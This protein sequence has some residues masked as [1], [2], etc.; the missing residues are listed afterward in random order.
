MFAR[1]WRCARTPKYTSR[2]FRLL[3]TEQLESRSVLAALSPLASLHHLAVSAGSLS[4][5][6]VK[7]TAPVAPTVAKAASASVNSAGCVTG[8]ST[9]LAVLGSDVKG[10]STLTYTWTVTS[11]PAGGTAKFSV[12]GTNAAKNDTVT[13]NEAGVYG[14]SV[15]IVDGAGLSV[16]SSVQINVTPTLS[17]INLYTG[18]AKVFLSPSTPLKVTGTSQSLGAVALDQFGNTLATQT[19]FAWSSN[20]YPT[21]AM[22]SF[23]AS[24]GTA[25]NYALTDV[26]GTLDVAKAALT[27]TADN[28]AKVYGATDPTLTATYS[29]L[30]YADT[31][32][33][34]DGFEMSTV[35]GS[36]ATFGT[37]D[38]VAEGGTALNY[39]IIDVNG[40]L[41]VAKADMTITA[42]NQKK[43]YG[44]ADP[45]LT[46]TYSGL[47]YTDTA[48][49]V[50]GF[51]MN[52]TTG[53]AATVGTHPIEAVGGT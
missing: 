47:Q 40:A 25:S 10:E 7:S 9:A 1:R 28:Q 21:G 30:Q 23:T 16:T 33:V 11:V 45:T 4:G 19:T 35:T 48:A 27:I 49:V 12:N 31:A 13:F 22:P 52:T 20:T 36:A 29:G 42:D 17:G 14:L 24:G 2:S 26:N 15:K 43:V 44:A 46:A 53:S 41:T 3:R 34:V 38:I 18:G 51:S 6:D 50:T 39:A 5:Q 32:A 37:H 8:T